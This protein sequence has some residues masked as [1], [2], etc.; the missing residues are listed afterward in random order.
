MSGPA[1]G[2]LSAAA[3]QGGGG[4]V[5][6][7]AGGPPPAGRL[8]VGLALVGS[9]LSG[10]ALVVASLAWPPALADR[11]VLAEGARI[12]A[13]HCAGCH[14][15]RLEGQGAPGPA[16]TPAPRLDTAGHAW[17]HPE[18]QLRAVLAGGSAA[19]MPGFAATLGAEGIDAV[20]AHVKGHWPAGL[21]L[22]QAALDGGGALGGVLAIDP[23]APLPGGCLQPRQ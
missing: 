17:R 19:G 3:A 22:H 12:Y 13:A 8:L 5:A 4:A 14:G 21:R 9:L 23:D 20:L 1:P 18:A 11:R 2:G 6:V 10:L 15:A 16:G 7:G